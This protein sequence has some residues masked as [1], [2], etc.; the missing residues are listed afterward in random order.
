MP[1]EKLNSMIVSRETSPINSPVKII[2]LL[3]RPQ[4]T[5][6]CLS[7][8][9]TSRGDIP[10]EILEKVEV[11]IKYEGYIKRQN[12]QINEMRRLEK[13]SLPPDIDYSKIKGIRIEACEK[14][15]RIR[16][17]NIG[18]ASRIS[19]VS[20]ADISVILIWLSVNQP[21]RT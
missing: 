14:L 6:D 13:K 15:N 16:P 19:G 21:K 8:F 12:R 18:Q 10:Q 11:E 4:I 2:D 5:Y 9:D 17:L 7:P 20:P 1:S 3:K